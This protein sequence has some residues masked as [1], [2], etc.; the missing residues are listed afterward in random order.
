MI[1]YFPRAPK[2]LEILNLLCLQR[3]VEQYREITKFYNIIV[4]V[5]QN[6]G[7]MK[8]CLL[9]QKMAVIGDGVLFSALYV[10][11]G[12]IMNAV[13]T[14]FFLIPAIP[15]VAIYLLIQRFYITSSR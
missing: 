8:Q 7:I 1:S 13:S 3:E 12:L 9:F 6:I 11:G 4:L 10:L 14:P 2:S 15:I 5:D